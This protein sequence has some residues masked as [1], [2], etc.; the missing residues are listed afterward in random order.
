M[1]R[2]STSPKQPNKTFA[3]GVELSL[4]ALDERG[5]QQGGSFYQFK[6]TLRP[7][8]YERVRGSIVRL[9]P[10]M[11]LPPGRFQLRVGV[12]ETGAGEMGSVFYDLQV[13]DYTARGL[14]MSGLLLT[15]EA[16]RLQFSPQPDDQLPAGSL[17]APAT[18]RRTF[19]QNDTVSAFAEIYDNN[20]SSRD[21]R[22]VEVTTTLVGE[23]GVAAFSSR[24]SVSGGSADVKSSRLP[25][26]K[27]IPLE[28]IRPGR[29]VFR[30]SARLLGDGATPVARETAITVLP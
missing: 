13:P 9:N 19:T 24:E 25:I 4:F 12:R 18:S 10:R 15:D 8:T 28:N 20:N 26:V 23:D 7:E 11:A 29:Y 27:Q 3:D 30:V 16:A 1:R 5:R 17:P 22:R 21:A 2:D 14:G 6:L